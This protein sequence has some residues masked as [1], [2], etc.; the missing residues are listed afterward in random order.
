MKR[1][2]KKERRAH[3]AMFNVRDISL[4]FYIF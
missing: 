4:T 3:G 1:E 2:K